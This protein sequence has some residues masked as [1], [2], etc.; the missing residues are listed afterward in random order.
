MRLHILDWRQRQDRQTHPA[1]FLR[2][3][4]VHSQV[5]FSLSANPPP[6][7]LSSQGLPIP[8]WKGGPELNHQTVISTHHAVPDVFP[9]SVILCPSSWTLHPDA[10]HLNEVLS[11]WVPLRTHIPKAAE[12]AWA[13]CLLHKVT[14]EP[15]PASYVFR[16]SSFHW[17][18]SDPPMMLDGC[19]NNG[20][21]SPG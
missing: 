2:L 15:G 16:N 6:S 1:P 8:S 11:S 18:A 10:L 14:P 9:P 7:E 5:P 17:T 21:D 19:A 13:R 12:E 4:P 3:R 20:E